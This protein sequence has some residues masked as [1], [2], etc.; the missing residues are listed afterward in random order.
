MAIFEAKE[1]FKFAIRIEEN[2]EKF[3]RFASKLVEDNETKKI[4]DFLADEEVKHKKIFTGLLSK[5]T[6]DVDFENYPDEYFEY[7]RYYIDN[8]IFTE[9]QLEKQQKEV[10]DVLSA[11]KFAMQQELDSVLYYHEVEKFVSSK[12][13]DLIESIIA[14]ERKHYAKLA[15]MKKNLK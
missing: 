9:E 4:F 11:I 13:K 3:Y 7:L 2:G 15:E 8:V 5:I 6:K 10:K 1:I 14:E 12:Q